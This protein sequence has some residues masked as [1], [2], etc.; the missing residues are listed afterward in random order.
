M[1]YHQIKIKPNELSSA[2]EELT[3]IL[4]YGMCQIRGLKLR[5]LNVPFFHLSGYVFMTTRNSS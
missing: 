1:G 4:M 3:Y 5:R 2:Q